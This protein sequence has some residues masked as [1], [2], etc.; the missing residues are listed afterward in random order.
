MLYRSGQTR[1]AHGALLALAACLLAGLAGGC[2]AQPGAPRPSGA[3]DTRAAEVTPT[4]TQVFLPNV[5]RSGDWWRPAPGL[6]WQWQLSDGPVDQ[7]VEAQVYDVDLFGTDAETVAQLHARGRRAICYLNVGAW[8]QYRPDAD[9]FPAALIGKEYVGWEGERWLDIRQIEALAPIMRARLDMCR[10]K[11]FDGV[12]PDN[13]D[14]YQQDTGFPI[15]FDDQL[16]YGR[17]LVREAHQRGLSIG[18]KNAPEQLPALL[19]EYDWAL[20]E[21]CF[22]QG[23]C[24]QIQPFVAAGKA[25]FAAEYTDTGMTLDRFCADARSLGFSAILKHRDL[26]V[27]RESC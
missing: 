5:V 21:D 26:D 16:A 22:A 18:L 3:A 17:W 24:D 8:E 14:G 4:P 10:S 19:A 27:Y 9:Q 1:A 2:G 25:V 7:S 6:S 20:T 11:G 23:W 13:I 15:T 12:E